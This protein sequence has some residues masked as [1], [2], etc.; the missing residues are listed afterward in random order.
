MNLICAI[1]KHLGPAIEKFIED[2]KPSTK[3]IIDAE[4]EKVTPYKRGEYKSSR[5]PNT[6]DGVGGDGGGGG[7][8]DDE[9]PLKALNAALPREDISKSLNAKLMKL[10]G[11]ADWKNKV[12]ACE[13]VN[14]L[15][16]A[17]KHRI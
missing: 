8:G 16:D 5:V 17:A 6:D 1:Y 13:E 9:D 3:Q 11:D 4:F 14:G 12:K 7:G 10:F 15:L 2:I